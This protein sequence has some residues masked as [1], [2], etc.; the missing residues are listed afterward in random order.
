M[1]TGIAGVIVRAKKESRSLFNLPTLAQESVQ[2]KRIRILELVV[3]L[4]DDH[5]KD[6][7]VDQ[8]LHAI[9]YRLDGVR[10]TLRFRVRLRCGFDANAI[11]GNGQVAHRQRGCSFEGGQ[12]LCGRY[13][14]EYVSI[15]SVSSQCLLWAFRLHADLPADRAVAA[16]V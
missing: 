3:L 6:T 12:R 14:S 13:L 4:Y 2:L 7:C 10:P 11:E 5:R 9:R 1:R 15:L 8:I 16:C